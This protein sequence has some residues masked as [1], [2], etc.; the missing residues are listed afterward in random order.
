MPCEGLQG[1][2]AGG[3]RQ[4]SSQRH[5]PGPLFADGLQQPTNAASACAGE[6]LREAVSFPPFVWTLSKGGH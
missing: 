6:T 1:W 2:K 5:G 3:R 4:S